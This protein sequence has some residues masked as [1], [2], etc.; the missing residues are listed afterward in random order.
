MGGAGWSAPQRLT[1][2]AEPCTDPTVAIDSC[3]NIY[4][5]FTK[6]APAEELYLKT[7]TDDG[8][9]WGSLTR[10]TWN[11]G[12]SVRQHLNI[13]QNDVLQVVWDDNSP[14]NCEIFYKWSTDSGFNW[15]VPS[16]LSWN[17][18]NSI[19]SNIVT[20]KNSNL[21]LVWSDDTPGNF[22]IF[23]KSDIGTYP[24]KK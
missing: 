6:S 23:Y 21:H 20:D 8:T 10:L 7:S 14:G 3:N 13:N 12:R 11:P 17:S 18:G 2:A 4:T 5:V 16:R 1:W 19:A 22:E 24:L 15:S 9:S